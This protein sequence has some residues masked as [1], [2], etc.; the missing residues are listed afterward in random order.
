MI[1]GKPICRPPEGE[2]DMAEL[3]RDVMTPHPVALPATATSVEAALALRDF[4][5]GEVLVLDDGQVL[6]IIT[7]RPLVLRGMA[8]VDYPATV[9][10]AEICSRELTIWSPTARVEDVVSYTR[11]KAIRRLPVVENG[12]LNGIVSLGGL[13]IAREPYAALSDIS[14][15]PP[16]GGLE[17][18]V[19]KDTL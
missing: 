9:K 13:A 3:V 17:P 16:D 7:D 8:N 2:K 11:E 19:S 4:A 10:S 6:G 18:L 15:A 12:Q 14:A 1:Y 5:I